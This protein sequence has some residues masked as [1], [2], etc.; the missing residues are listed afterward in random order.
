MRDPYTSTVRLSEGDALGTTMN[1]LRAWLD[2]Q[3]IQPAEFR[4][5]ADG[6]GYTFTIGFRTIEDATRFRA[7]FGA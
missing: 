4:T 1:K 7:Q 5:S 2:A 6:R 3:K